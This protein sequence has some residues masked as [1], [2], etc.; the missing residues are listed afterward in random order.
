MKKRWMGILFFNICILTACN[1]SE[2]ISL[3]GKSSH[4]SV[5]YEANVYED[6]QSAVSYTIQYTGK[7]DIPELARYTLIY[8]YD[9]TSIIEYPLDDKHNISF[10]SASC[11][12]CFET[13]GSKKV[14]MTIEWNGH[15]EEIPFK[16]K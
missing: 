6:N 12:D 10:P 9:K 11:S 14:K 4:W 2:R 7:K 15:K 1:S 5:S 16:E 3:M 8:P 13:N